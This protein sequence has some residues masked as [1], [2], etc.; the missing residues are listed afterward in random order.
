[1]S[2]IRS[3]RW[4]F[5]LNNP[6]DSE[7]DA[8]TA[9][10]CE[11]IIMGKEHMEEGLTPHIQG[12]VVFKN[13]KR[14]STLKHFN[15]RI[16]WEKAVRSHEENINYCSK[17]DTSPYERGQRPKSARRTKTNLVEELEKDF[18]NGHIILANKQRVY[19]YM[20][21][22]NMFEEIIKNQLEKP[23]VVYV[24]GNTG[25]GKTYW[26]IKDAVTRY[27]KENVAMLRF[28]NNFAISNNPQ[29]DA[30]ILP[31]FRPSNIDAA[32]FLEFTDGYGMILNVKHSQVYIRPKAVYICSIKHP[33]DIYKEEINEQFK[34]RITRFMDRNENPYIEI[35]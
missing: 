6:T 24:Y 15:S 22:Q 33:D 3:C 10:E 12:Y 20:E 21:E 34:R 7:I 23:D 8:L 27:G 26:A 18:K 30:L 1:M 13:A 2:D 32:T 35:P 4:A 16:H 11:Y 14:F 17:E 25:T 28:K 5:T 19:G 29:A 31:E 9:L